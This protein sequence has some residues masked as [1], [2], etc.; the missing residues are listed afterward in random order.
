MNDSSLLYI[1]SGPSWTVNEDC[2]H[3]I[4]HDVLIR[5]PSLQSND[6][7]QKLLWCKLAPKAVDFCNMEGHEGIHYA[8][9]KTSQSLRASSVKQPYHS[10]VCHTLLLT[11][12]NKI[13]IIYALVKLR[14][15]CHNVLRGTLVWWPEI[16]SYLTQTDL[17]LPHFALFNT[18]SLWN[19]KQS[20]LMIIRRS[21]TRVPSYDFLNKV[22]AHDILAAAYMYHKYICNGQDDIWHSFIQK[23][24]VL[25]TTVITVSITSVW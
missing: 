12:C 5:T 14:I 20:V 10:S 21:S 8:I 13:T 22:S 24:H 11:H 9:W 2:K 4:Y 23:I 19:M 16:I 7:L 17:P 6:I 1:I 15:V 3:H 18:G 25:D